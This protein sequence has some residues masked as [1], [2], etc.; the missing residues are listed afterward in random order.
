MITHNRYST[1]YNEGRGVALRWRETMLRA[2]RLLA[3]SRKS[4]EAARFY[5][6]HALLFHRGECQGHVPP[7]EVA[8]MRGAYRAALSDARRLLSLAVSTRRRAW[9]EYKSSTHAARQSSMPMSYLA[10]GFLDGAKL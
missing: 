5:L 10:N 8:M 1:G 9:D 2:L 4:R 6:R 7:Y 3:A